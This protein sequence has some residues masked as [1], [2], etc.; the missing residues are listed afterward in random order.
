LIHQVWGV[1]PLRCPLCSGLL[2]P[3]AVVESK[4]EILAVLVLLGLAR[5]H[6]RLFALGPPQPEVNVLIDTATGDCHALDP[7]DFPPG[8]PYPQPRD[9]PIRFRPEVMEPG[10]DFDQTGFELPP[11]PQVAPA[12]AG[13][14][15]LFGDD[16]SQCDASDGEPIFG[17]MGPASRNRTT[18]SFKPT[19]LP[20]A[21]RQTLRNQFE[22]SLLD[23]ERPEVCFFAIVI[24]P[25]V[26]RISACAG[27]KSDELLRFC[28]VSSLTGSLRHWPVRRA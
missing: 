1:A 14:G 16:Y 6:E 4:A 15:K 17:P 23:C 8:L 25:P 13:Q 19:C 18:T 7:P 28:P 12:D 24:A 26:V 11:P 20:A 21:H 5:T 9:E 3:T 22:E 10:E 27:L 2:R